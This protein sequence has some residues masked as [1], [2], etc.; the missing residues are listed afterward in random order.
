MVARERSLTFAVMVMPSPP[1]SILYSSLVL[2]FAPP[3][4]SDRGTD[5]ISS[6]RRSSGSSRSL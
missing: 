4:M 3:G 1:S 6:L 5:W 2:N